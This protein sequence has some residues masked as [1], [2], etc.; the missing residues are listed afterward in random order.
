MLSYPEASRALAAPIE[1]LDPACSIRAFSID[2]R[3]L[4]TG[5]LFIAL[6]GE[7]TD[8]HEYAAAAFRKGASG[9]LIDRKKKEYV[10]QLLGRDGV[11]PSNLLS[12]KDPEAAMTGLA[13]HYRAGL[14]VKT[15][16]ITG[17]VG[18]TSTKEFLAYLLGRSRSVLSTSGNLNNH[19]G[20]PIMISRLE[21]SHEF[22]VFE[23][24]A[25]RP[26]DIDHLAS[27]VLPTG[28]ILT[29]IGPAHLA[30]FGSVSNIYQTKTEMVDHLG[31]KGTLVIPDHDL[32]LQDVLSKKKRKFIK[33]GISENADYRIS[34][35]EAR[36]GHVVFKIND[37]EVFS[38]PG[39]AA[40]LSLN[41]G[42]AIAMAVEL[43]IRI[44]DLPSDWSDMAF[45]PGRFHETMLPNGIRVIDDSYNASPVAF[46]RAVETFGRIT[47]SG[48]K[49]I[50]FADM[51]ELG[52]D[53]ELYHRELGEMIAR[54]GVDSVFAFGV[55]SRVAV[56][57]VRSISP[58]G[59]TAEHYADAEALTLDLKERVRPGD[60]VLFK[61]SRG[62]RV[63]K[64]LEKIKELVFQ[65]R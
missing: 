43:G 38:F 5:D 18:K 52:D 55:R 1:F 41:A 58:Q 57:A 63:E 56:Q 29:P 44:K 32:Y 6:A 48:K 61:A 13:R 30:G 7:H 54:S 65:P 28:A 3:T 45:V 26:G 21:P 36:D 25:S 12:V 22:A 33:V 17:S 31:E 24:G 59:M 62:M 40:F 37:S 60:L 19:L 15:I 9:I 51:L 8:G 53:E 4:Q 27:L 14:P 42:L 64:V 2:S 49:I 50:V 46:A 35:V 47:A 23:M 10:L 16:G 20:V 34:Q 39:Q 11:R